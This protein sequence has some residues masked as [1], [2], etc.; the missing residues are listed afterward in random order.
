MKLY[1]NSK[2]TGNKT[3]L[4]VYAPT[5]NILKQKLGNEWLTIYDGYVYH[6]SE[7]FAEAEMEIPKTASGAVIGGLLGLLGG[8]LGLLLGA[9]LGGVIGNSSDTDEVRKTNHF[10]NSK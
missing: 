5:R 4:N 9:G 1:V 10:N 7:V 2:A 3:Y 6:V 8:P